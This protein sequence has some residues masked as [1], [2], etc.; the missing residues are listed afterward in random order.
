MD[1]ML[2]VSSIAHTISLAIAPVFLLTGVASILNVLVG[3]L[4]RVVD[5]ARALEAGFPSGE[6]ERRRTVAELTILDRRIQV[7]HY[8]IACSSASALLVC[9]LVAA[10]F[11][12][13][14]ADIGSARIVATLFVAA[15]ALII[16]GLVLFLAEVQI[17][18]RSIRVRRELLGTTTWHD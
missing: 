6:A 7:V 17:A 16:A 3:R 18:T 1:P 5:R 8:A 2:A 9:V 15:M 12:A 10:L 13:D 11:I 14:L 4:A